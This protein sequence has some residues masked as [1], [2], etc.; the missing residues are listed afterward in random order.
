MGKEVKE[1]KVYLTLRFLLIAQLQR[2]SRELD[3][4]EES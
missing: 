2:S 3:P 4:L 1:Y